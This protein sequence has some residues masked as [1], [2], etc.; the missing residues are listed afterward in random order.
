MN[1]ASFLRFVKSTRSQ[2]VHDYCKTRLE[3]APKADHFMVLHEATIADKQ[4]KA[5]VDMAI[6]LAS[7]RVTTT[8]RRRA[9]SSSGSQLAKGA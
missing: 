4:H 5:D 7:H 6:N 1:N 9:K 3:S 2:A 8:F